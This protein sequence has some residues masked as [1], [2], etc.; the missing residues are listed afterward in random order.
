MSH[1][2]C[3]V[4]LR[5]LLQRE[6]AVLKNPSDVFWTESCNYTEAAERITLRSPNGCLLHQKPGLPWLSLAVP[7]EL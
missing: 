1:C 4:A 2:V 5:W 7:P 3:D 6:D